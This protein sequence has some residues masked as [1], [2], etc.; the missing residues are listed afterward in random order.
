MNNVVYR[1]WV[2]QTRTSSRADG[3]F[4]ARVIV[5]PADAPGAS[6]LLVP[7]HRSET[8]EA[9]E[10]SGVEVGMRFV[11]ALSSRDE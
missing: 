7:A 4:D 9:A 8:R 10:R 5:R 2:I 1:E 6:H 3:G 11:D